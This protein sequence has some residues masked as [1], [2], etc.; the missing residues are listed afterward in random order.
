VDAMSPAFPSIALALALCT[1]PALADPP[2]VRAVPS[3]D[4]A[5]LRYTKHE[6][7]SG[8]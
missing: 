5:Q 7:A 3:V 8:S 6:P 4:L 1:A 2:P